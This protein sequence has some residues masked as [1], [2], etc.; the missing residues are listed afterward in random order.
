M[1]PI[2]TFLPYNEALWKDSDTHMYT[3]INRIYREEGENIEG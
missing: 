3:S 1:K 2:E